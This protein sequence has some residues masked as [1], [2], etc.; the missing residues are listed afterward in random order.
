VTTLVWLAVTM[1]TAPEHGDTL[2]RF[3]KKVRPQITGWKPVAKI[4]GDET[5]TR[6]LGRNLLSWLLGCVMVY[7][8]LACIGALCF[9]R[10]STGG[11]FGAVAVVSAIAISRSM[12]KPNEWRTD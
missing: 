8:M 11:I 1:L 7:S 4:A 12:P 6:D 2:V 3:Y 5:V 10:Y 9:G